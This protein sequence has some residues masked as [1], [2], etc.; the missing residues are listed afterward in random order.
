MLSSVIDLRYVDYIAAAVSI[1]ALV[2]VP[3]DYK[4]DVLG[5][6]AIYIGIRFLLEPLRFLIS[7]PH[8]RKNWTLTNAIVTKLETTRTNCFATYESTDAEGIIRTFTLEYRFGWYQKHIVRP[9]KIY[10]DSKAPT[11][12]A[13]MNMFAWSLDVFEGALALAAGI[14]LLL[15]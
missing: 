14:L 4:C 1:L 12:F 10:Y 2:F 8:I 13:V 11:D 15:I 9:M 6:V 7:L 3:S 5:C